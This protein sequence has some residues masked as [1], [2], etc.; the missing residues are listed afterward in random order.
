MNPS[1]TTLRWVDVAAASFVET[2]K[3]VVRAW[4]LGK[5]HKDAI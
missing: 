4:K 1:A 5:L 2:R 3:A